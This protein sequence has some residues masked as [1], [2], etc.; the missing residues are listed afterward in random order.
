M[1]AF[2]LEDHRGYHKWH[3]NLDNELII[4]VNEAESVFEF[5]KNLMKYMKKT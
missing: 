2:R 3:R 4:A 1:R 5:E